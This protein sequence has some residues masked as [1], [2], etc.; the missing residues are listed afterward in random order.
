MIR[1]IPNTLT[2][3]NL[4][5]GFLGIMAF[6][7]Y[8]IDYAALFILIAA[9][10]DFSDGFAARL[11]NVKSEIGKQLDTLADMISFGVLPSTLLFAMIDMSL[12]FRYKQIGGAFRIEKFN[13]HYISLLGVIATIAAAIRLAR[14]NINKENTESFRGLPTPASAI[15]IASTYITLY[16]YKAPWVNI[17][18]RP[19]FII[20][21]TIVVSALML[22]NIRLFTLKFDNFRWKQNKIRYIFVVLAF[23]GIVFFQIAAI[24]FIIFLY[25]LLSIVKNMFLTPNEIPS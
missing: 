16:Y 7:R 8:N 4:L 5:C 22:A 23:G 3:C 1:H 6:S 9:V 20:G 15:L 19:Q 12:S 18:L 2:V 17:L 21:F 25:I 10:F 13:W 14:F 24:P 11:L